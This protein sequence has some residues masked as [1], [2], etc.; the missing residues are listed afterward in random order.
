M[1]VSS[2][3]TDAPDFHTDSDHSKLLESHVWIRR[4]R[5]GRDERNN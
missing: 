5:R 2:V 1:V 4:A 3:T